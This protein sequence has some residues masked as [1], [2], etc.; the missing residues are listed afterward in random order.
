AT[1]TWLVQALPMLLLVIP[2][3]MI[4]AAGGLDLS[5]GS[6]AALSAVIQAEVEHDIGPLLAIVVAVFVAA[7]I[8]IINGLM[9]SLARLHGALVTLAMMVLA[10]GLATSVTGGRI[11]W[12]TRP[13]G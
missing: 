3:M 13:L 11:V 9:V 7:V 8:G 1:R 12:P 5:V 2:M 10:R 4:V 6:V